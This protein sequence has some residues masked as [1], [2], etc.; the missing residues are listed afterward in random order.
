MKVYVDFQINTDYIYRKHSK[1]SAV[2]EHKISVN[3]DNFY[4]FIDACPATQGRYL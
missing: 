2:Y 3:D 1:N 4:I